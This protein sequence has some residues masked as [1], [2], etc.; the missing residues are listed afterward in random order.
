[1]MLCVRPGELSFPTL[2]LGAPSAIPPKTPRIPPDVP[3]NNTMV[4][5]TIVVPI[6]RGYRLRIISVDPVNIMP[7]VILNITRY[8]SSSTFTVLH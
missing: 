5:T 4:R 2:G 3:P 1:M 8:V 7:T 6:P